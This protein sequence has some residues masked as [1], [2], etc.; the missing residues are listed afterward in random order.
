MLCL[1]SNLIEQRTDAFK[2]C[3]AVRRPEF[4]DRA[5]IGVWDGVFDGIGVVA[6]LTN[7]MLVAF[8]GSQISTA[9][10][11]TASSRETRY[12]DYR[13]WVAAVA[14]EHTVLFFRFFLKNIIGENPNWIRDAREQ[15]EKS[16]KQRMQVRKL[17]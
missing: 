15:L 5:D 8:V 11:V 9:L 12:G 16:I 6:V 2:L 3:R 14:I 4:V 7:S 10:S 1:V 17:F 13:H